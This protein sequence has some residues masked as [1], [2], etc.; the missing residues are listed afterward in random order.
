MKYDILNV[1]LLVPILAT[2]SLLLQS[3]DETFAPKPRG[4]FRIQLPKREYTRFSPP[5]CPFSFESSSAASVFSDSS[6][7]SEP[8]WYNIEYNRYK[9]T[10]Y[11]SYKPVRG[12]LA[13]MTEDCR[14]LAM[15][16]VAKA[17]G[18][19]E[20]EYADRTNGVY[21]L[22]YDLKGNSAS[23]IQFWVTDSTKN[24]LRGSLYFYAV[25]NSDSVAPILDFIR[26]DL[27]HL[28]ESVRWSNRSDS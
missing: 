6:R 11:L 19:E 15:K 25:P 18:I 13:R 8:C 26:E 5:E 3:C 1:R 24:F 21:G 10:V 14:S 20:H 23:P 27:R 4:Y 2:V 28:M 22:S 16:H 9:A 12:D 7:T 17:S